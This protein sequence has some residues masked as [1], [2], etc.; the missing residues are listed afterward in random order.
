LA[1]LNAAT[2]RVTFPLT[3]GSKDA[4][5]VSVPPGGYTVQ[6]SGVANTTG[7]V[8]VKVYAIL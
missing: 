5:L 1:D 7:N 8:L 6:V 3:A 4:V 2:A